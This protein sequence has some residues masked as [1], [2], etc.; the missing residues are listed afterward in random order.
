MP[1]RQPGIFRSYWIAG[2]EGADHINGKQIPQSL[3][4]ANQHNQKIDSD[5]ALLKQF[6]IQTVRESIGWRIT[7]QDNQFNWHVLEAKA[8]S[9]QKHNIQVIWTLM[10][11]GWPKDI[12][13]LGPK[14]VDRF[15]RYCEAVAKKL[16]YYQDEAPIYQPL[17]EISFLSWAMSFTGLIHPFD[18]SLGHRSYE[19]KRQLVLAALRGSEAIWS[20]DPRAPI[21]HTD[22]VVNI[23]PPNGADL[24][25]IED[26]NRHNEYSFQAW[27]MI[28][29]DM[30][31]AFGG[32]YKHLDIIGV[33]Y[34]H[35]NQWVHGSNERLS[36]HLKDE[37]RLPFNQLVA[38]IWKR[39]E[40]PI[41]LAETS[42]VG[43][44]RGEWLDDIANEVL[45]CEKLGV[46]IEGICLYPIIDRPDWENPEHWHKSGLWDVALNHLDNLTSATSA[47]LSEPSIQIKNSAEPYQRVINQSYANRLNFWQVYLPS[48]SKRFISQSYPD[49]TFKNPIDGAKPMPTILVFSHLRWN[50]VYQRPQHLLSRLANYYQIIFVEEPVNS[51][52]ENYLERFTPSVNIEVLRPHLTEQANGFNDENAPVVRK[53]ID[54]FLIQH[55]VNDYWLWFYTPLALP[56]TENMPSRGIIYYC[57]DE[58]SAFKNASPLLLE[59]E[60]ALFK[61][62]DI[63]FTGGPSLYE[64]KRH[65]HGNVFCFA[66]SVDA[67]HYAPKKQPSNP[68]AQLNS[69]LT[70][71][72][73]FISNS[74]NQPK[75]IGYFGVIDERIDLILIGELADTHPEWLIIMVGP[76]V[77]IDTN[78]LPKNSN[79]QWLGQKT[80]DELPDLIA[81][82]DLCMMPFA[83]NE[84]TRFISPTKTLEY[85]ASERAVV[86]TNIT[87]VAVPY[88]HVVPIAKSHDEFIHIC[89][90]LLNE[91]LFVRA[92]RIKTMREIVSK[93]SW[94]KTSQAMHA[95]IASYIK[96]SENRTGPTVLSFGLFDN[97]TSPSLKADV[98]NESKSVNPPLIQTSRPTLTLSKP[99]FIK[100]PSVKNTDS[101]L[102]Y[103]SFNTIVLGAGPTGLS[104]AYH[105]DEDCLL[106]EKL[107]HVGGW[108]RSIEDKG[109]TFDYAG[110]I[111]FSNDPYVLELYELL[112][113]ENIHWQNREA[114]IYSKNVF[115]RYPFQGALYGLP[116]DVLKEC[117][118]GAIEAKFGPVKS[119]KRREV[120]IERR[121]TN[122]NL[123][124]AESPKNF[125]EF[126]YKV[127]GAG[128]AKHFAIPY[129]KKL[130]A[131]PL[132]EMETSWLGNRVPMPDLE[133]MIEGALRPVAKPMGPNA[134]FGYP[135]KGGFQAL[136]NG[137]LPFIN[138][139]LQLNANIKT[140]SPSK[141]LVVLAD[142]RQYHYENLISTLPLP[143]LVEALG[144]EAPLEIQHAAKQLRHV[145]VKCVNLGIGRENITDKHWIY[146]P[147]ES[148]FHRIFVQGNASPGC[149]APGGFALTCEITYSEYKPLLEQND[150]LIK[151]CIADCINVGIINADDAIITANVVDM[152]YA[153]VVY[154]HERAKNVTLI[155][156]WLLERNII[157]SGR[158]SE[159][160]YY[161]SDHAFIAGKKAAEQIKMQKSS[162]IAITKNS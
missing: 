100:E 56:I 157:L 73:S 18:G 75:C 31:P 48:F 127:W 134:R 61:V 144:N 59:R 142:G 162:G 120:A 95:L 155:R 161:N 55:D 41:F 66:S 7:E 108:C 153:Y 52:H 32:S 141:Q 117:V 148:I 98:A 104:A 79:I 124:E 39:Y 135:L 45:I 40:R 112:L 111:M 11:Y 49:T 30:E 54:E 103:K 19:I 65:K 106:L 28:C 88:G 80:Y 42:H 160:E 146:Y 71:A 123:A 44:G 132:T 51:P 72:S 29:G 15:T 96:K 64:S 4:D 58:L 62:A 125:E 92:Q 119:E 131:V 37:R 94:D 93:T 150:E 145:S 63:V 38:Q 36:W 90:I 121:R 13:P 129:N 110:H 151:R 149:N 34:Y 33:N 113:G 24:N 102:M 116:P 83:L 47:N 14:F 10:H 128:V 81:E 46:P 82:W 87:D 20:V 109:F 57:M 68:V 159:W 2:Y 133:E 136:M 130:W 114:W 5:Y 154:D 1:Q 12:D 6:N 91:S 107:D 137:F 23:V 9:A 97:S 8:Q 138:G 17:N 147:E 152:P 99:Q 122:R 115:T 126:I 50:F 26:T 118:M 89:E 67:E 84:S 3:N 43:V 22:P 27:D 85:M 140:I 16:K 25:Q 21:I 60:N 35:E 143:K 78:S 101:T 158:Y 53:L 156:S 74:S 105:L 70:N 86:S 77:K 69:K 76:V 139:K